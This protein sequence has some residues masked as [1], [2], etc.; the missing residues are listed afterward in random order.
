M[1]GYG[2]DWRALCKAASVEQNSDRLMAL[3]TELIEILDDRKDR[4]PTG[5]HSLPGNA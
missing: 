5:T 3:L 4:A 1:A 2:Q